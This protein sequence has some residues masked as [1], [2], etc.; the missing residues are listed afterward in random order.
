MPT[1]SASDPATADGV[2]R[3]RAD[4][5]ALGVEPAADTPLALA[6]SGGPDSMAMLWLAAR[7]FPGAVIAATVDHGL[8]P[9]SS[10]EAAMV[11][12]WCADHGVDHATL[13]PDPPLA[14][15]PDLQARARFARYDRLLRWAGR[16]DAT[17]ATAH[18]AD[19]Q[20][21][22]FLMRANRGTGPAGLTGIRARRTGRYRDDS[23]SEHGVAIVRPL[24]GW[25]R[26]DLRALAT[27]AH[28]PFIDDPSNAN[29]V[30]ERVAVRTLLAASPWLDPVQL[31]RA[32]RHAGEAE[33]A[34]AATADWLW[35]ARSLDPAGDARACRVDVADLPR[36]MRRRLARIAIVHLSPGFD[37]ATNIEPLLDALEAGR[38]ATQADV[39]VRP[40]GAIWH[41]SPAPPRRS[42]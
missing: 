29:P 39:L 41:F 40:K 9:E 42:H 14:P 2:A 36:E 32:A 19:D 27:A 26:A 33:D 12:A 18:H 3:F 5:L 28:V 10:D 20:A 17:L 25:R 8:R 1:T 4:V 15:G 31:A 30:F 11:A 37:I 6:V 22:T 7:A 21:E 13:L 38:A 34:L 24:L 16:H 35:R 23:G